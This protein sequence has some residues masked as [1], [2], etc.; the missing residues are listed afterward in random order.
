MVTKI[1]QYTI[2]EVK[3]RRLALGLSQAALAAE[4]GIS[5]GFVGEVES[6][7]RGYKYNLNHLNS[8]ALTFNC[9][10]RDLLPEKPFP[11]ENS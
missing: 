3:R 7:R 6:G 4:A 11:K 8:F 10:V 9:S 5:Y 2:D 1:E